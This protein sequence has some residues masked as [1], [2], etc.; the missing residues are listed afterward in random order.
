MNFVV[1]SSSRG[2]TFQAVLDRIAD[3][4]LTAKCLG[5]IADSEDRG[6]IQ[7]AKAASFPVKIIEKEKSEEREDYDKR[8]HAAIEELGG[9]PDET[10]I[11]ALGW[12]FILSPWFVSQWKNRIIN[13]HPSLLPKYP[14]AHA[15]EDVLVAGES[16]SGMTIHIIDEGVDT[17][18]ILVQKSCSVMP[19]DT[20]D[21]LKERVQEL[22]KEWYPK[23]LQMIEEGDIQLPTGKRENG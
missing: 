13:V 2:T 1:L 16:E 11:A 20:V 6:C 15:H 5:L 23:T 18:E 14:G 7:K 10:V 19:D 8:L 3:G 21:S 4:S 9:S 12:M 22:E 17:G